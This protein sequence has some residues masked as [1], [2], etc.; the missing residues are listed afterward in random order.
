[1]SQPLYQRLGHG[2]YQL[3]AHYVNPGVACLY[4]VVHDE[5][6]AI[7]ETGT[8]HSLPYVKQFL[9]DLSLSA[10]QVRYVVPTHVHL[11]HAGGAGV[12]MRDFPRAELVIHPRGAR[13]MIDPEKLVAATRVVYGDKVFDRLYG[14]IP[15]IEKER[16]ISAEH[17]YSFKL[18]ERE[19]IIIDTPG[20]AYHHFC[21]VDPASNGI[22]TGDTFGLSYPNLQFKGNR[23]I[24]PT[25]TPS[26]FDPAAL[27]QSIDMMMSYQPDRMY[28]THFGILPDPASLVE[29][30]HAMIDRY[31]EVTLKVKPENQPAIDSLVKALGELLASEF[32]LAD[33]VV[34]QQMKMDIKLNA[35]GL[36]HWYQH[37]ER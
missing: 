26:H 5:Q 20:H 9:A 25:S 33:D 19:F 37:R 29:H 36:A 15:A 3:D 8:A 23:F 7:I 34:N 1:M 4:C 28:M 14:E 6:V 17:L 10:D 31:V 35:Q 24:I 30:Y 12:M 11:D 27:H 22:F 21:V 13:H 16:V 32:D 2:V 18:G